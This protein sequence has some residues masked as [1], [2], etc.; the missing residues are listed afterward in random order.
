M[1]E[2]LAALIALAGGL[3][4]GLV[5]VGGGVLFV[6]ALAIFIGLSQVEAESTSLMMIVIVAAVGAYRQYGH[7]NL[8]I[9]DALL[10]GVLS[11][12]GVVIGVVAS[13]AVSQRVLELCFAALALF[14][15]YTLVRRALAAEEDSQ[16]SRESE[17]PL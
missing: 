7:G 12:V 4:G 14:V 11:P 8:K 6:P 5:G 15:A 10:I 17:S 16:P 2:V 3:A 1:N 13:N 9:R